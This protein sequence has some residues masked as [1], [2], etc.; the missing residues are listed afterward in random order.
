MNTTAPA[1]KAKTMARL[2][3]DTPSALVIAGPPLCTARP[4]KNARAMIAAD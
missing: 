3:N 4:P 2:F 1:D